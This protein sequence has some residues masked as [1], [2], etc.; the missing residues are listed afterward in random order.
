MS[1]RSRR[2]GLVWHERFMWHDTGA[3]LGVI[4]TGVGPFPGM[5]QPSIHAEHPETKRRLKNLLDARDITP[6][7]TPIEPFEADDEILLRF[8]DR[9]YIDRIGARSRGFG[10]DV[11]DSAPVGPG[12]DAIARLAVGGTIRALDAV[13]DGRVDNAYVLSRPPGHHAMPGEGM[14][15]CLYGNIALAVEDLLAR[16]SVERVAVIDW[17]VHHGNGTEAAFLD[18]D[19]VLTLS[20]HQ[21]MLYPFDTGSFAENG[22][23][24]G[25]GFNLNV[26]LPPGSGGGAWLAAL[27]RVAIPALLAFRPD[28]IVVACGFDGSY[29]DPL[30]H[31]MLLS[32]HYAAMTGRMVDAAAALCGGRLVLVHEGGYSDFYVPMCGLATIDVLRGESSDLLNPYTETE[33]IP[34]QALQPHQEAVIGLVVEGPLGV[35]R[36]RL[37]RDDP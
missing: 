2:T 16:G 9:A 23:G 6:E 10:G 27:D 11:G 3:S 33:D 15:F 30:S 14:G 26:P 7:L 36:K 1:A 29:F 13:V 8:H 32:S 24:R 21:D 17:D 19:D 20:I 12:S 25:E 22:Q 18:R 28:V 37:V 34:W 35:L 31:Q 4:S 5:F